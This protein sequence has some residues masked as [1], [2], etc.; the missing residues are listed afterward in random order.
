MKN[1][2][3]NVLTKLIL[4]TT[5][6]ITTAACEKKLEEEASTGGITAADLAG[7]VRYSA[8]IPVG[9]SMGPDLN[10]NSYFRSLDLNDDNTY[11]MS[12]FFY[13]GTNCSAGGQALWTYTTAGAFAV[14][15]AI[16]T[17]TDTYA[18]AY[19]MTTSLMTMY[20]WGTWAAYLN[21]APGCMTNFDETQISTELN[22]AGKN[23]HQ[24]GNGRDF[25]LPQFPA[26]NSEFLDAIKLDTVT[27]TITVST[28]VNVWNNGQTGSLPT[29]VDLEYELP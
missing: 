19:T 4:A 27:G 22:I 6:L 15:D 14:G 24:S 2:T 29:S 20:S 8:C 7:D 16:P 18:I 17:L 23:C 28:P 10:G 13:T 25:V 26:T 11:T 1:V 21:D 12:V 5:L 3:G 9:S